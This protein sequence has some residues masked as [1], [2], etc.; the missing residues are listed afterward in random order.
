MTDRSN[1]PL[2]RVWLLTLCDSA[3]RAGLAPI[4][5]DILHELAFFADSLAPV[6]DLPVPDGKI[7]KFK[8]G[9]FYP[10]LQW[11]IDRLAVSSLLEISNVNRHRDDLGWWVTAHYEITSL[12]IRLI[13][14]A[15]DALPHLGR[16]AAFL[17]EVATAFA[18]LHP[19][20]RRSAALVDANFGNPHA[21]LESIID[22]GEWES[23]NYSV[24]TTL[25]FDEVVPPGIKLRSHE[26]LH[27]YF[28][29]L[30]EAAERLVS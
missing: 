18:S 12:G 6:Y 10:D 2:Q 25:F 17:V 28:R 9:P 15:T 5:S 13:N 4:R 11:H 22:Y 24:A 30:D 26:R 14:R 8:R 20:G 27:L 19:A 1:W 21:H 29:Y 3:E 16:N 23:R 7:L